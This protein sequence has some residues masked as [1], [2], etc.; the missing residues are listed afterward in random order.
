MSAVKEQAEALRLGLLAGY[1][2]PD[3]VVAWAD[4]LIAAGGV[5]EPELIAVSLGGGKPVAE[6]ARA[7]DAFRGEVSRPRLVRVI[8]GQ[9][10]RAVRREAAAGPAVARQLFQMRLEG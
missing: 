3:E 1:V 5:P 7:L 4:G 8:L 6:L 2:T 10:A 9:M